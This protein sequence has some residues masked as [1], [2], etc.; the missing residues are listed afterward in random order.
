MHSYESMNLGLLKPLCTEVLLNI[1]QSHKNTRTKEQA[2][3]N[4]RLALFNLGTGH[5]AK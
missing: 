1:Q 4:I 5:L 2:Q 3:G